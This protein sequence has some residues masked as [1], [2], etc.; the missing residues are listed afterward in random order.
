MIEKRGY[1]PYKTRDGEIIPFRFYRNI[2]SPSD[3]QNYEIEVDFITEPDVVETLRPSLLLNVQ[4]D[5]Q[6]ARAMRLGRKVWVILGI[7]MAIVLFGS[8]EVE[9]YDDDDEELL[10]NKFLLLFDEEEE[11]F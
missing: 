10:E 3:G 9:E 2:R 4:R 1:R 11:K 5:L 6:A 8:F 7:L